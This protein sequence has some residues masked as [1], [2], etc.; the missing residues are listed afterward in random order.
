[1]M[2]I[3]PAFAS[4]DELPNRQ[5]EQSIEHIL[6]QIGVHDFVKL[7][8]NENPLG[9]SPKVATA[10]V[11]KLS[12][13]NQYPDGHGLAL[14]EQIAEL[15]AVKT[16][17]ITLGNGI[18]DLINLLVYSFVNSSHQV[19]FSQFAF[20]FYE[21]AVK[22]V[23][24]SSV[25]VPAKAFAHDLT[26]MLANIKKHK[27]CK[28]VFIGNPNN[29]TG[30]PL[31]SGAIEKFVRKVPKHIL[32]VIDEATIE[33]SPKY[34]SLDLLESFENVVI[35]RT[36]SKAYG[37][38]GMRLGYALSSVAVAEILNRIRPIFNVNILAQTA[39]VSAL[40][41][42]QFLQEV[43]AFNQTQKQLFYQQFDKLGLEYL[44]SSANFIMVNVKNA[45]IYRQ[46][47]L[48]GV[49][50]RPLVE[51]GL[52]T[53]IRVSVGLPKDNEKFLGVLTKIIQHH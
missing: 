21:K 51:Y 50:V 16:N 33:Y 23:G 46:L 12:Q 25:I 38:A 2:P 27:Q 15:L 11:E 19:V 49:V 13:L 34:H 31:T 3:T 26:A 10:I 17:Q 14:K 30:L 36:F 35:L 24:A 7:D 44:P 42:R 39:G 28:M 43:R 8:S 32:V 6:H 53:W 37:L 41:D 47:L 20:A 18:N 22:S 40:R 4:I 1:M 48:N 45:D 29:P 5:S 9:A 52:P